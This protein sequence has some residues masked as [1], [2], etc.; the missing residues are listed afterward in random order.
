MCCKGK[1][2]WK[3]DIHILLT[4]RFMVVRATPYVHHLGPLLMHFQFTKLASTW[5]CLVQPPTL[6]T[7]RLDFNSLSPGEILFYRRGIHTIN[8]KMFCFLYK[9]IENTL[10]AQTPIIKNYTLSLYKCIDE[11]KFGTTDLAL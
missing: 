11:V 3:I 6:Y 10:L 2:K 1:C 9:D 4:Q 5:R 8:K 7:Q